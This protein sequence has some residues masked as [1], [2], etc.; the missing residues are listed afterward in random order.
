MA[1]LR[2]IPDH[3][4]Y[5]VGDDGTVWTTKRKGGNDRAPGRRGEPRPLKIQRNRKGYC[6][7]NIDVD[8]R[9]RTRFLHQLVLETFVGP[10]P[11]G[12]EGCHYPDGDKSNNRLS[13]LR[14]DTHA[15]NAR[16]EYRDRPV[17]T[18]K[19]CRRC[20]EQKSVAEFYADRRASDGLKTDCKSCHS[21][22]NVA[23]RDPEK[24]RAANREYMRRTRA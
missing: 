2:E 8:G 22:V 16:D 13:N 20:R 11:P 18:V 10:K 4:G 9:N 6:L 3:P 23:T 21:S 14:W 1:E 17:A 5:L 24:K 15:E 7:V 12:M 19:V